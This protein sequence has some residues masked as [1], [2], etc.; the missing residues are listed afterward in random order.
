MEDKDNA[1]LGEL[2]G[3]V[4][5][6][7]KITKEDKS[8]LRVGDLVLVQ[9]A[10]SYPGKGIAKTLKVYFGRITC[11]NGEIMEIETTDSQLK[12]RIRW[13]QKA[14]QIVDGKFI[15]SMFLITIEE[16]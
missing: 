13:D 8:R 1:S 14:W 12:V 6:Y 10:N 7:M 16:E 5:S 9:E 2:L 11:F 4:G 15:R 3:S